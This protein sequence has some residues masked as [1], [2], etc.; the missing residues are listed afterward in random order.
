MPFLLEKDL[1]RDDVD[2]T[3]CGLSLLE[4]E[5]WEVEFALSPLVDEEVSDLFERKERL[6]GMF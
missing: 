6:S 3:G 1:L 4:L 5:V 2:L